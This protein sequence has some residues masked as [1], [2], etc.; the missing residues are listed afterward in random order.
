VSRARAPLRAHLGSGRGAFTRAL[1]DVLGP[2]GT[3]HTVDCDRR[4]LDIQLVALREWFPEVS[5]VPHVADFTRPIDLRP[6]DGIVMANSL[7]FERDKL[8]VLRLVRG[9]LKRGGP[10][11]LVE[12]GADHGNP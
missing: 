5:V 3:I 9:Y 12:Y 1:A 6:L 7:D 2:S 4:A 11:V 8:A 10:F